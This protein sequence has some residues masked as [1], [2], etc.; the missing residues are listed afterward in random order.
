MLA[1]MTLN[2][3]SY[4]AKHGAWSARRK[5]I[6]EAIRNAGAG[7]IAL[8]AVGKDPALYDGLD[9]AAQLAELLQEYRY[10]I[11][12]SVMRYDDGREEGLAFLSRFAILGADERR[13]SLRSGLED[14]NRRMVLAARIAAPEGNLQLFNAHFSWVEEQT[15]DNVRETL[16]YLST[17]NEPLMLVG[18]MNATADSR[19]MQMLAEAGWHDAW[20]ELHPD[21]PGDTFESN[22]P[23]KRIDYAWLNDLLRPRLKTAHVVA[24]AQDV[25]GARP[26]DHLGLTVMVD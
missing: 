19:P 8:Q 12:H 5:L 13:L 6:C 1:I 17:F 11:F 14:T 26:S 18:D 16:D 9:Q 7:V 24:D 10:Q 21:E 23:A 20:A 4:G 25:Q 15:V 22:A 3:N 2:I